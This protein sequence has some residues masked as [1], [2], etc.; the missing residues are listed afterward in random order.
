MEHRQSYWIIQRPKISEKATKRRPKIYE[1]VTKR[2]PYITKKVTN[3][4]K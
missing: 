2:R 3:I 4:T 1:K